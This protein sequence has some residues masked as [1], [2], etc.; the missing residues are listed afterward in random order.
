MTEFPKI[1]ED[2]RAAYDARDHEAIAALFI[3]TPFFKGTHEPEQKTRS[4]AYVSDYFQ[5]ISEGRSFQQV[6]VTSLEET[7]IRNGR[8]LTLE[9]VFKSV[10]KDGTANPDKSVNCDIETIMS[11]DGSERFQWFASSPAADA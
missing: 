9:A 8:K 6:V 10:S 11:A 5:K 4:R 3:S 7:T 2:F 1:I